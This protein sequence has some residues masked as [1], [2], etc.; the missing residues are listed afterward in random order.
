M[1]LRI[2]L[3]SIRNLGRCPC[4]RCLIPMDRVRNMGMPR[5]MTQRKSKSLVRIDNVQRRSRVE[6]AREA[7][8]VKNSAIDGVAVQNLLKEDSLVP[9]AVSIFQ[10]FCAI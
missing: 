2:L 1:H 7:I 5:D 6:A 3:A 9:T 4:P 8:Y 10:C